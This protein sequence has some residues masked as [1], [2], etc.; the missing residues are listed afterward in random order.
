MDGVW[1]RLLSGTLP[2]ALC[3]HLVYVH[4][5][6]FHKPKWIAQALEVDQNGQYRLPYRPQGWDYWTYQGHRIHYVRAGNQPGSPLL[7][8]YW[9]HLKWFWL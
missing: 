5:F 6:A 4:D 8:G 7:S 3:F 2:V 1:N 9:P